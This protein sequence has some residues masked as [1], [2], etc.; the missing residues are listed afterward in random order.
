[1][2]KK[3]DSSSFKP[4][5]LKLDPTDEKNVVWWPANLTEEIKQDWPVDVRKEVG[6]ELGKVQQGF[7]P[8][9]FRE[10]PTIGPG[11]QE[12]K[13]Q[14]DNKSQYRL[15]YIAKFDDGIYSFHVITK[16]TTEQTDPKDIQIAR[17]RLKEIIE[18]RK[19]KVKA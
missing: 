10:M 16:K 13:V 2:S 11:V 8:T 14:D 3:A 6:F 12:I 19:K 17:E 9:H 5:V 15:I 7:D 18:Y 1:M 4:E